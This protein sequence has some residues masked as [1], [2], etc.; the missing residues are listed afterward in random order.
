MKKADRSHRTRAT[1]TPVGC[2]DC[3]NCAH[4]LPQFCLAGAAPERPGSGWDERAEYLR[5]PHADLGW[6]LLPER[7]PSPKHRD[8]LADRFFHRADA[9]EQRLCLRL[10]RSCRRPLVRELF[11]V[12]SRLGN[13]MVWYMLMLLV[14]AAYGTR[15][16]RPAIQMAI[17]GVVG[18]A[19]YLFLKTRLVRERPYITHAGIE[20]HTAPSRRFHNFPV[21]SRAAVL[22]ADRDDLFGLALRAGAARTS[23]R[24]HASCSDFTLPTNVLA[25]GAIGAVLG[26]TILAV[27]SG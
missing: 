9:A 27:T 19:L 24:R 18:A 8:P 1:R 23:D 10:N 11:R 14:P 22:H 17:G 5:L 13:G 25:G 2:G 6:L 26:T 16:V 7:G 20:A 3:A 12:V 21:R 4:G 15:G